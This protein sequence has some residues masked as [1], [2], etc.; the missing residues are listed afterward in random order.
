MVNELFHGLCEDKFVWKAK[1]K[2]EFGFNWSPPKLSISYKECYKRLCQP[3]VVL[4]G[5]EHHSIL[6]SSIH[7]CN[8]INEENGIY[9]N[10]DF[11]KKLFVGLALGE[12]C[13]WAIN[14]KGGLFVWGSVPG[15]DYS[16]YQPDSQISFKNA[17]H[18]EMGTRISSIASEA[19]YSIAI[20]MERNVWIIIRPDRPYIIE[21]DLINNEHAD[22][23]PIQVVCSYEYSAILTRSG[24]MYIIWPFDEYVTGAYEK[25]CKGSSTRFKIKGNSISCK[26]W[27]LKYDLYKLPQIGDLP[28]LDQRDRS[29]ESNSPTKI[30]EIAAMHDALVALT[31]KGDVLCLTG[32]EGYSN[33]NIPKEDRVMHISARGTRYHVLRNSNFKVPAEHNF[34]ATIHNTYINSFNAGCYHAVALSSCGKVYDYGFNYEHAL[35][36]GDLEENEWHEPGEVDFG[37]GKFCISV[38][39]GANQSG[40]LVADL[41]PIADLNPV[42]D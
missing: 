18:L 15:N 12:V 6:D 30:I 22:S 3:S 1:C 13:A 42:T 19:G 24:E 20:D 41:N 32:T 10:P 14:R 8:A 17:M 16:P 39:A 35:G 28:E 25:R 7:E 37:K 33:L 29:S 38:A 5:D 40:A 34:S 36:R 31:D 9:R 4:W 23:T 2:D 11:D 26:T 27:K 21:S